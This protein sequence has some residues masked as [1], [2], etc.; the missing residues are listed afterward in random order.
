MQNFCHNT[1]N[2]EIFFCDFFLPN[3]V[4]RS[5]FWLTESNF[6]YLGDYG[7]FIL[8]PL[9]RTWGTLDCGIALHPCTGIQMW[10]SWALGLQSLAQTSAN[11][12]VF[13]MIQ[14]Y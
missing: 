13:W 14:A 1:Q 5:S 2:R 3:S 11:K 6:I 8:V 4:L 7:S 9:K 12:Q 10:I